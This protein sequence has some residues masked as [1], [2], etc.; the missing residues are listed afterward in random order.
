[1]WRFS[2]LAF[3]LVVMLIPGATVCPF[4][5]GLTSRVEERL[6]RRPMDLAEMRAFWSDVKP[7]SDVWPDDY[8]A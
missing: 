7:P 3:C 2:F 1:V 4:F 8:D 6:G 5:E